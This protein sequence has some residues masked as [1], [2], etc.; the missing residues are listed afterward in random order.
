MG[1]RD[2]KGVERAV[3]PEVL[4]GSP[5]QTKE[6]ID[7]LDFK[8][9]YTSGVLSF[10]ESNIPA[11][12]KA[13]IMDSWEKCLFPGMESNQY[14]VLWVEHRDK[15]RLELNF[16]IPNVELL[17]GKR[18]QPYYDRADRP[19]VNAWQT[20]TN[21]HHGLS[22]P[23]DPLR[24][25]VMTTSQNLPQKRQEAAEAITGG[26]LTLE[27]KNRLEVIQALQENGFTVSRQTKKSISIADPEGGR[28]LRL[29]GGIYA[30]SYRGGAELRAERE[31]AAERY[32]ADRRSRVSTAQDC[33]RE[34]VRIRSDFLQGRY[35]QSE[36]PALAIRDIER[37]SIARRVS[38]GVRTDSLAVPQQQLRNLQQGREHNPSVDLL[39]AEDARQMGLLPGTA[40]RANKR[41]TRLHGDGVNDDRARADLTECLEGIGVGARKR[42]EAN[43]RHES[44]HRAAAEA[45]RSASRI[46][47]ASRWLSERVERV[48]G[49]VAELAQKVKRE[50]S[51]PGQGM[52]R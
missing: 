50:L 30:E 47:E 10:S 27:P 36:S 13:E 12:K 51:R 29:S 40:H 31:A 32:R 16:V 3:A 37:A 18:L 44:A 28:P 20:L 2:A 35:Q 8:R 4:R 42:T 19:R 25:R 49:R 41:K 17:S 6:L 26:L 22:D 7:T 21:D 38:L 23:N 52:S 46:V 14:Q 5:E 45:D 48:C 43:G 33:Y 34:G 9:R 11:E 15:G 1:N 24:A 39:G